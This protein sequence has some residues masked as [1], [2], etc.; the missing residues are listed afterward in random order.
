M[1]EADPY[2]NACSH[3]SAAVDAFE[4]GG[5]TDEIDPA[6]AVNGTVSIRLWTKVVVELVAFLFFIVV[7]AILNSGQAPVESRGRMLEA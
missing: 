3:R 5:E 4:V 7:K 2:V 1:A 6:K